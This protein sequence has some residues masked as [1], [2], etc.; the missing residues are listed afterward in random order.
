MIDLLTLE[1]S[2]IEPHIKKNGVVADFTMGNGH[3]TLWLSNAVGE[4]GKVYAFDIQKS[5]LEST[6]RFL[7]E[8]GASENYILIHDSHA[9]SEMHIKEK[10]CAG[11]FNLGYLPGGDKSLTTKRESTMKAVNSAISLLDD[12]GIILIAIYPGHPEG[13]LEGQMLLEKLQEL[14]RR[15]YCV[16]HFEILN[17]KTSP[18]FIFIEKA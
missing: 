3:D 8:N 12:D 14:N 6:E 7:K 10:I 11:V 15:E 5:A 13:F 16:G 17:S 4:N 9:N 1:K 2:F 18:F